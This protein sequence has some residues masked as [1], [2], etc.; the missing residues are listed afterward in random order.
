MT[1]IT[2]QDASRTS[3]RSTDGDHCTLADRAFH[4]IGIGGAGMSVVAQLLAARGAPVG[5][6]GSY[7]PDAA[8]TDAAMRPS[9]TLNAVIE[10]LR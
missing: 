6:G 3:H 7:R 8:L 2:S 9:T 10:A 5:F 1:A 4:L